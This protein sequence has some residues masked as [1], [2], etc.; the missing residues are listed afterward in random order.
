M[1]TL[2]RMVAVIAVIAM[3]AFLLTV[4]GFVREIDL[5][6][7]CIAGIVLAAYDFYRQSRQSK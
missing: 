1:S 4:V 6:I 3:G 2:D 7:V 5:A